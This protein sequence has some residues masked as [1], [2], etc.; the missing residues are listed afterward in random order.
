M[1]KLFDGTIKLLS[2][3]LDYQTK[4]HK[5]IASNIAN[6]DTPNYEAKDIIFREALS[7]SMRRG[8]NVEMMRSNTRHLPGTAGQHGA[9]NVEVVESGQRVNID[10]EM[11]KLAEN[12]LR[13]NLTVELLS[14]KFR[15]LNTVL[16]EVK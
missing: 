13:Y 6:I 7:D 11:G 1:D 5:V 10:S 9:D 8:T 12:H 16:R 3:T 15:S 2:S 4:R 14:R